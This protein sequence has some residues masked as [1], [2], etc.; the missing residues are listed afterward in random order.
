MIFTLMYN[1]FQ[2]LSQMVENN[3]LNKVA[4]R[5]L[6]E[7]DYDFKTPIENFV[8]EKIAVNVHRLTDILTNPKILNNLSDVEDLAETYYFRVYMPS[9]EQ[10]KKVN[11]QNPSSIKSPREIKPK[12]MPKG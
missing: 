3:E 10:K 11:Q 7:L 8:L 2:K 4:K 1:D 9:Q 12:N 5:L 6:F